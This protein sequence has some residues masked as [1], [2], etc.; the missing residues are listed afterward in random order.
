MYYAFYILPGWF[1]LLKFTEDV[2]MTNSARWLS[3]PVMALSAFAFKAVL[4][5]QEAGSIPSSS[6]F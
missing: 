6:V 3:F 4:A 5:S 2:R 1:Y